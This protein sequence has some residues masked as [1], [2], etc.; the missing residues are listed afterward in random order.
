MILSV[1]VGVCIAGTVTV[2]KPPEE[3]L[4]PAAV[5][6]DLQTAETSIGRQHSHGGKHFMGQFGG[7]MAK[8]N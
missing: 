8:A 4:V 5:V 7:Y 6:D 3:K 2:V 1:V